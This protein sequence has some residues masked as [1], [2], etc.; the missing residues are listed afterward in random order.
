MMW[1][2]HQESS[3][4]LKPALEQVVES[5]VERNQ[6]A[7]TTCFHKDVHGGSDGLIWEVQHVSSNQRTRI[8]ERLFTDEKSFLYR[9]HIYLISR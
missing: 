5:F 1:R 6:P 7:L 8:W 9:Q 4:E 2:H 3:L